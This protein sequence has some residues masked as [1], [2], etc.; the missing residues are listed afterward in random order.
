LDGTQ[1]VAIGAAWSFSEM[2]TRWATIETSNAGTWAAAQTSMAALQ[3]A[4]VLSAGSIAA[5]VALVEVTPS[6]P[7][8]EHHARI[9]EIFIQNPVEFPADFTRY[10]ATAADVQEALS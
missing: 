6:A 1:D 2:L 5:V 7:V 3:N 4:G 8:T 9:M 10:A